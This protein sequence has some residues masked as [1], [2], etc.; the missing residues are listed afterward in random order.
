MCRGMGEILRNRTLLWPSLWTADAN[1]D[2]EHGLLTR[3]CKTYSCGSDEPKLRL[4]ELLLLALRT[5]N[6]LGQDEHG[7]CIGM[8]T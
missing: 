8:P 5:R 4:H 6:P 7:A 2:D 1:Q 3:P